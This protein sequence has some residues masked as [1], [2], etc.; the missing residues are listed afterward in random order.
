LGR[1]LFDMGQLL[2]VQ[3]DM[4]IKSNLHENTINPTWMAK[5]K[6]K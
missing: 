3:A 2:V 5:E 4:N 6:K 1:L